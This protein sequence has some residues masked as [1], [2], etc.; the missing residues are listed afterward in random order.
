MSYSK[1]NVVT[2]IKRV[3]KFVTHLLCGD[4]H[5]TTERLLAS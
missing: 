4:G 1:V 2:H 3:Q 5:I